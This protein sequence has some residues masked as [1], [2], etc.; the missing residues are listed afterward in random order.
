MASPAG[1]PEAPFQIAQVDGTDASDLLIHAIAAPAAKNDRAQFQSMAANALQGLR[2]LGIVPA[3]VAAGWVYLRAQPPWSA[4]HE[5][6][7]AWNQ[8]DAEQLPVSFLIQPPAAGRRFCEMQIH[9]ARPRSDRCSVVWKGALPGPPCTTVLR[10]GARHLRVLSV[11]PRLGADENA[12]LADLAYDMFASASHA[13][14][15]RGLS[16][17]DVVR[18]WIYLRDIGRDYA[19]FNQGRRQF[20]QSAGMT[21]FP[22]STGIKAA[23]ADSDTPLAMDLYA[24]GGAG[25]A[26]VEAMNAAPMGE[27]SAY[28]SFFAR[29][30]VVRELGQK[31]AFL[32]GTASIDQR[33][34]VVAPGDGKGQ[35][36]RMFANAAGVLGQAGLGL[37][38]AVSVTAYLQQARLLPEFR[39]AAQAAGLPASTPTAIVVADIC[40][41]EW[42][43]EI[44]LVAGRSTTAYSK[45]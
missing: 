9:A 36:R 43:C 33:G 42:L 2:A 29:G 13:L 44:E 27:A 16:F 31:I 1:R 6:A 8:P 35:L 20:F 26:T 18:T 45:L 23:L 24:V 40:R 41:P 5:L 4:R 12:T 17:Y 19:A 34:Q 21:R 15:D 3:D 14:T 11:V 7:A 37:A 22:A 28:G 10:A 39:R 30:A 25:Q 38:D 32:S